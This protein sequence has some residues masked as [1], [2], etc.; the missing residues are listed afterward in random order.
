[1]SETTATHY[2]ASTRAS[3]GS[4]LTFGRSLRSLRS[5]K[6]VFIPRRAP[7]TR[8][9][10]ALVAATS[11]SGSPYRGGE[12]G[13]GRGG[14]HGFATGTAAFSLLNSGTRDD[15]PPFGYEAR[16]PDHSRANGHKRYP[17]PRAHWAVQCP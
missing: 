9:S 10:P 16:S 4:V 3:R 15:R 17:I 14:Q 12:P 11:S 2:P 7:E 1:M 6:R 8:R 5:A 13:T